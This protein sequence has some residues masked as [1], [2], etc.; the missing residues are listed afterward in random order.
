M[1]RQAS[2]ENLAIH[3]IPELDGL[4]GIAI[5]L[6]V[7]FH[8][9]IDPAAVFAPLPFLHTMLSLGSTGVDLFFVLSGFL[10]TSILLSTKAAPSRS[11][12]WSFYARRVLRIFPLYFLAVALFFYIELPFLQRHG[13]C[14]EV[15]KSDQFWYWTYLMNW[16]DAAG[17]II[18]PLIHFWSLGIEEQFYFVWPAVV[19]FCAIRYFPALCI[20]VGGL[21]LGLRVV[22]STGH[23]IAPTL[24][25]EFIHR[26]TITRLDTLAVGALIA[27]LVVN[28]DWTKRVRCQIKL[29]APAAFGAWSAMWWASEQGVSF[30]SNTFGYLAIA[31]AFGC[32]VFV[33]VTDQGSNH[34]LC[35]IARWRPLR[36]I[37]G[38]SYAMYVIHIFVKR[39]SWS[40]LT[41][42]ILP[43][44]VRFPY[45]AAMPPI[46]FAFFFLGLNLGTSYLLALASWHVFEKHFLRLK[47]YFPYQVGSPVS[48]ERTVD[49]GERVAMGAIAASACVSESGGASLSPFAPPSSM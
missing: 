39:L 18:D 21:S 1:A 48:S 3:H 24:L 20:G 36:S 13:A 32:V 45:V 15:I 5:I 11:Y 9:R 34:P 23:F 28:S 22:L 30:P 2:Q 4:R 43:R 14:L 19:F 41:S 6:V 40:A 12:F 35:R 49:T 7:L 26:A 38:Y 44:L 33:C 8:A 47:K 31:I 37:G 17:H 25:S 46:L 10:I 42:V 16:H 29:I 27:A